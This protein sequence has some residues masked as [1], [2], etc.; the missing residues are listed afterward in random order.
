MSSEFP[1]LR[2]CKVAKVSGRNDPPTP[3]RRG[4]SFW[5]RI[6]QTEEYKAN[7]DGLQQE[8]GGEL[9]C[10]TDLCV[11][12]RRIVGV[13]R[14]F[15]AD[16][17]S[18]AKRSPGRPAVGRSTVRYRNQRLPRAEDCLLA[19]LP[20][21]ICVAPAH[22]KGTGPC[23]RPRLYSRNV[24]TGRKMDQSPT[25]PKGGKRCCNVE[26][27]WLRRPQRAADGW[28]PESCLPRAEQMPRAPANNKLVGMYVHQHWP[29]NHPY[30]AR[31]WAYEDWHGYLDGLHR[32]G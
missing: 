22:R 13:A 19:D 11:G 3:R 4:L 20:V 18:A 12:R 17:P 6:G 14:R 28:Y 26:S 23:F 8:L 15:R 30:A 2:Q 9:H 1:L 32:L 5:S 27:S 24:S 16:V 10:R 29:Y 25:D 31:T 7:R 21:H